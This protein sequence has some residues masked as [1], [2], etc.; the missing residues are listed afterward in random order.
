MSLRLSNR[1]LV[2]LVL[3]STLFVSG[4]A[5]A[6]RVVHRNT[7]DTRVIVRWKPQA[8]AAQVG[9]LK[10]GESAELVDSVPR[11]VHDAP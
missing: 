9:A 8:S 1:L 6:D 2:A 3:V 5:F 7:V 10:P 4:L 11:T